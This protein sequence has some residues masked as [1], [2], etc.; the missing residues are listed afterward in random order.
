MTDRMTPGNRPSLP[1]PSEVVVALI[2]R[3]IL[4]LGI[5]RLFLTF[6]F[7]YLLTYLLIYLLTY[8]LVLVQNPLLTL[9]FIIFIGILKNK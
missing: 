1:R 5:V 8:L 7:T 4:Q 6:Y 3:M 2:P 9:P